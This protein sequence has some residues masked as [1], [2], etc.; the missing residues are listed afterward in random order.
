MR[1]KLLF[2]GGGTWHEIGKITGVIMKS[3]SARFECD[4][5]EDIGRLSAVSLSGYQGLAMY[6]CI[7]AEDDALEDKSRAVVPPGCRRAVEEYV[8]SGHAFIP[9]HSTI[10]SFTDWGEFSEMIGGKWIWHKSAHDKLG[11]FTLRA[12]ADHPLGKGIPDFEVTDELYH[13]LEISKPVDVLLEAVWQEKP[14][15]HAWTSTYGRG[16]VFT[17]LPGHTVEAA[18]NPNILELISRG[19]D[20]AVGR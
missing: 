14:A 18:S 5:T 7:A 10:V 15:P 8:K 11:P 19:V 6:T 20:W 3:I 12:R 13:T 17:F 16:R 2:V 9:L 4:Y 1:S